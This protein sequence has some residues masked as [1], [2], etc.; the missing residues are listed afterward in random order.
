MDR[1]A[2]VEALEHD[3]A[4]RPPEGFDAV[5]HVTRS[6]ARVP[7]RHAVEVVLDT[8]LVE[9]R[10]RIPPTLGELSGRDG[11]VVLVCRAERLDGMAQVLAGF[12]WAFT[13]RRPDAL[14]A[15]VAEL[16]ERLSASARG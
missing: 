10:E 13:I 1:V 5:E 14:R 16:A 8:S 4:E 12:G 6:L 11:A 9:A 2:R 15:A 7:W 3:V